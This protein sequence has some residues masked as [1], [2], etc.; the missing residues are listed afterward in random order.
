MAKGMHVCCHESEQHAI[1]HAQERQR[2]RSCTHIAALQVEKAHPPNSTLSSAE[3][4]HL[5][6]A[7]L[8]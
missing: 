4:L 8:P 1:S 3:S 2:K 6:K 5:E 7:C